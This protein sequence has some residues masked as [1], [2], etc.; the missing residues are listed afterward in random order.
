MA[1]ATA[2]CTPLTFPNG[3]KLYTNGL[4]LFGTA[5]VATGQYPANGIPISFVLHGVYEG[6]PNPFFGE[7]YSP[8]TGVQ[9]EFDPVNQ[10]LRIYGAPIV[11]PTV[12]TAAFAASANWGTSP[13]LALS[14]ASNQAAG[15][16]TV[17]AKAS[18]GANPTITYT[19]PQPY[20]LA[21]VVVI[22]RGN[23]SALTSGYWVV[24]DA[25]TTNLECI[26]EFVGTP[27]ANDSYVLDFLVGDVGTNPTAAVAASN[28]ALSTGWGVAAAPTITSTIA[29]STQNAF[30][31]TVTAGSSATAANPTVTLTFP[32]PFGTA[33]IFTCSPGVAN[34]TSGYWIFVSSTANTALF[35]WIGTPT[36]TDVYILDAIAL[37]PIAPGITSAAFAASSGWGTGPTV[38]PVTGNQAA[39]QISITAQA[40]TGANPTITLTIP[41]ALVGIATYV[42]SRGD[43]YSGAGYWAVVDASSTTT[44][45]VFKF[46]GT[47]T[48]THTYTLNAVAQII[49][50][51][52]QTE[53]AVGGMVPP[54]VVADKIYYRV[55]KNLG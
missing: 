10:S 28:F 30:S 23:D 50:S 37:N 45:V 27:T 8:S 15:S 55:D 14:G 5:A 4:A 1:L 22:S 41:A 6:P 54:I 9:Y 53:L 44:T 38:G 24:Q 43:S 25:N 32:V 29:N 39:F 40:S 51:G 11:P 18:T 49:Q 21:P 12:T 16:L 17:G 46:V 52:A 47:P 26:F 48:A 33:P 3:K 20:T 19:F 42:V 2:T 35:Q 13:T 7:L 31:C 34:P 36:A